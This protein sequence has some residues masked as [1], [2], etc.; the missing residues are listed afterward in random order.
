MTRWALA[1]GVLAL[2]GCGSSTEPTSAWEDQSLQPASVELEEEDLMANAPQLDILGTLRVDGAGRDLDLSMA[3][4]AGGLP[5]H[6]LV[7]T[8][9]NPDLFNFNQDEVMAS[10]REENQALTL[11]I[12]RPDG[13]LLYLLEPVLP[14]S[15]AEEILGSGIAA[16]A[17]DLG[18][19]NDPSWKVR[20][21][22]AFLRT[23]TGDVE[24]FPGE[25]QEVAIDG[26]AYRAILISGYTMSEASPSC[27]DLV[28]ERLSIE[29]VQVEAGSVDPAPLTRAEGVSL[30]DAIC[31]TG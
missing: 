13:E 5:I 8:S 26:L 4:A 14:S 2:V 28:R 11:A 19:V 20:L 6:I 1:G 22:S 31:P 24:L 7:H 29:L 23:D 12:R 17:S 16:A 18:P 3:P 25:P 9:T 30:T 27:V 10:L 21:T 15:L